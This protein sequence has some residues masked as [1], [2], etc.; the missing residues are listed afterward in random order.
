MVE[1]S[2]ISKGGKLVS[3]DIW[4]TYIDG[5]RNE[6]QASKII[7][8]EDASKKRI[9]ELFEIAVKNRIPKKK[10]G[11]FFS[12]GVDSTYIAY[13]CKKHTDD[14]ICYTVGIDGS[15]DIIESQKVAKELKLD[16]RLKVLTI[17]EAR[18]AFETAA[19]ILGKD[20]INIVSIGVGTVVVAGI[21]LAKKDNINLFFSGLGSE[22]I[23][24]GYNRHEKS[25]D[26]NEECWAGLLTTYNRDFRRDFAIAEA[27]KAGFLTPFLDKNL[28]VYA[29]SID[30]KLKIKDGHKKYILRK[31]A[32]Y[33][34]LKKEFAF[35]PKV[36]AQY[37]SSFDKAIVKITKSM[38]F[39]LKKEYLDYLISLNK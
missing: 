28:V 3:Y 38:G 30:G 23:F 7:T 31:A 15:R 33:A 20:L 21:E 19:K 14:F 9:A 36:A 18:V 39:K 37:G 27:K 35:R 6:D 12:G 5:L 10:F 22:E 13:T 2:N 1:L 11:I 26:I 4:K 34:G 29:M 25:D 8:S 32:E 17:E 24:A 16:H